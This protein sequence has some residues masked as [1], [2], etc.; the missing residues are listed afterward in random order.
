MSKRKTEQ[1]MIASLTGKE[2]RAWQWI[3][4]VG[5]MLRKAKSL[6]FFKYVFYCVLGFGVHVKNMQDCC[7]G[8]YMAMWFAA[9]LPITCI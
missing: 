1:V 2:E 6:Q 7:I 9:F 5:S 3:G 8:T 4:N